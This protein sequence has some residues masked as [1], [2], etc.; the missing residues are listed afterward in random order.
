MQQLADI[1]KLQLN[2]NIDISDD[3][4]RNAAIQYEGTIMTDESPMAHFMEGAIWYK[5]QLKNK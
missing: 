1:K 4:I 5:E 3:E 2:E